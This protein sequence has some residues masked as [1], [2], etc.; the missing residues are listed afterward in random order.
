MV[1]R[2]TT[3]LRQSPRSRG[4]QRRCAAA[5]PRAASDTSSGSSA[6]TPCDSSARAIDTRFGGAIE[7]ITCSTPA[8]VSESS[9]MRPRYFHSMPNRLTLE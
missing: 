9:P 8:T 7:V 6:G 2:W 4:S 1:V 5:Q 3:R